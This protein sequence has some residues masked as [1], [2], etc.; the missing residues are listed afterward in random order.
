MDD[1]SFGHIE[2]KTIGGQLDRLR[3]AGPPTNRL[4]RRRRT[5]IQPASTKSTTAN[6]APIPTPAA[7]LA[8][9]FDSSAFDAG[10][11]GTSLEVGYVEAVVMR[12]VLDRPPPDAVEVMDMV[13]GLGN[14]DASLLLVDEVGSVGV[15]VPLSEEDVEDAMASPAPVDGIHTTSESDVVSDAFI[16]VSGRTQ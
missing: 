12:G 16:M 1:P 5:N 9:R 7:A 14:Q 10:V 8:E 6:V 4:L 15:N 2:R 13:V 3:Y 11:L